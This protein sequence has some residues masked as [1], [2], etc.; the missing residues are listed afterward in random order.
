MKF[1]LITAV[2]V[3]TS[4]VFSVSFRIFQSRTTS[5]DFV[6][7]LRTLPSV[8]TATQLT[9]LVSPIPV[10]TQISPTEIV[11]LTSSPTLELDDNGWVIYRDAEAGFSLSYPGDLIGHI[12]AD[13]M[14]VDIQFRLAGVGGYQGLS[15]QKHPNPDG[16][17]VEEIAK[18]I[19]E[20]TSQRTPPADF[21]LISK[22]GQVSIAGYPA[23]KMII[24]SYVSEFLIFLEC[25]KFTL[26]IGPVHDAA[27]HL[28]VPQ[29]I[30]LFYN[31]LSTLVLT[32]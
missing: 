10:V 15:I 21:S 20:E 26:I 12:A 32:P 17:T 1:L 3:L 7:E 11:L 19:Y 29:A 9:S 23:T 8:L 6:P 30:D 27:A 31:I 16:K 25:G 24:P 5:F 18:T 13:Y 28:A 14:T 4:L 2:V 22:P